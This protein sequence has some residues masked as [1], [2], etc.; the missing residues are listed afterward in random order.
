MPLVLEYLEREFSKASPFLYGDLGLVDIAVASFV[1]N[2]NIAGVTIDAARWPAI[3]SAAS[4]AF[5]HPAFSTLQVFEEISLRTALRDQ[6]E[7]LAA[8]GAPVSR[9]EYRALDTGHGLLAL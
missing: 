4:H 8:A 3:H 2:A 6:R 7:A 5:K 1:R 9:H